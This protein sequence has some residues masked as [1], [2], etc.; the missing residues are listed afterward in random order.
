MIPI[1]TE[2]RQ[3]IADVRRS[4]E[5]G[6]Y[7]TEAKIDATADRMLDEPG[8]LQDLERALQD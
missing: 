5:A 2:A 6:D 1:V 8:M 3:K 4:I 7:E